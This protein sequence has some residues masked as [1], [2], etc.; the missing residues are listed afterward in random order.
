MCLRLKFASQAAA[1]VV[2]NI[3]Q[4][5]WASVNGATEERAG[6]VLPQTLGCVMSATSGSIV[7]GDFS[8]D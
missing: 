1:Y 2:V 6:S 4:A 3:A 7:V 5:L 8:K